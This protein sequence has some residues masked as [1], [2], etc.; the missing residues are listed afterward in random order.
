VCCGNCFDKHRMTS[1]LWRSAMS[2]ARVPILNVSDIVAPK[3]D[4]TRA[5]RRC[6]G[7]DG[8]F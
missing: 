3:E 8:L 2:L 6:T 4:C 7:A 1:S 5:G